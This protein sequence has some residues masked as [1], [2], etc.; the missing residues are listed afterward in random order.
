MGID[1]PEGAEDRMRQCH[2][3]LLKAMEGAKPYLR[4]RGRVCRRSDGRT[5]AIRYQESTGSGRVERLISL[6]CDPE[7]AQMALDL[8][9]AW[10]REALDD[11]E[12]SMSNLQDMIWLATEMSDL[13]LRQARRIKKYARMLCT[14]GRFRE[15]FALYMALGSIPR[16][17]K[18]RPPKGARWGTILRETPREFVY[19]DHD[20]HGS[21][22]AQITVSYDE[23]GRRTEERISIE[24]LDRRM[25]EWPLSGEDR[26]EG[27][28]GGTAPGTTD[29]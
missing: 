1:I 18:G 10:Q 23:Q 24:E 20:A 9:C 15:P 13:G 4:V 2:P 7:T 6:G 19:F 25:E 8:I 28:L 16:A 26:L 29:A 22:S 12:L 11:P 17:G 27:P 14:E 3:K 5:F 21:I